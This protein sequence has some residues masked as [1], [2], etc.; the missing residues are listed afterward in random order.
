MKRLLLLF[1]L[2][3]ALSLCLGVTIIHVP[4]LALSLI[5]MQSY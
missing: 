3:S 1:I 4:P 5:Q 2:A